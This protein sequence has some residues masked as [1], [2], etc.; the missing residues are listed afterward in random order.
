MSE[1]VP[2]VPKQFIQSPPMPSTPIAVPNYNCLPVQVFPTFNLPAN[3]KSLLRTRSNIAQPRDLPIQKAPPPQPQFVNNSVTS[4]ATQYDTFNRN[5]PTLAQINNNR[6]VS[7]FEYGSPANT[8]M[9]TSYGNDTY[10]SVLPEISY[11]AE[12]FR[13]PPKNNVGNE[14]FPSKIVKDEHVGDNIF[15]PYVPNPYIDTSKY[16]GFPG[17]DFK[18]QVEE[19]DTAV[20]IID[21][22]EFDRHS[23]KTFKPEID[24]QEIY[25]PCIESDKYENSVE[26]FYKPANESNDIT[27]TVN[28]NINGKNKLDNENETTI[29][30][31]ESVA[32]QN[33]VSESNFVIEVENK[34]TIIDLHAN[35]IVNYSTFA[36]ETKVS[37]PAE[38]L[39]GADDQKVK[40]RL[41]SLYTYYFYVYVSVFLICYMYLLYNVKEL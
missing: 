20:A 39:M 9:P 27:E 12:Y 7:M 17:G 41:K 28:Q 31:S 2:E 18:P 35:P 10:T 23:E 11:E 16:Q 26:D 21:T 38:D 30:L 34:D 40:R 36:P 22:S 3:P 13:A 15:K 1:G 19:K 4:G 6:P 14:K 33:N 32:N 8:Y 29:Q 24:S 5:T 25:L 37:K